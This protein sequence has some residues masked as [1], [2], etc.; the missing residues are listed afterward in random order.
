M[1]REQRGTEPRGDFLLTVLGSRGSIPVTRQEMREFGGDTSCYLLEARGERLV[2]DAGTGLANASFSQEGPVHILLS[3][4]H[5]DHLLGLPMFSGLLRKEGEVHL[6]GQSAGGL[7]LEKQLER[8][9]SPPLWP[10]RLQDYPA[11]VIC[12]PLCF[13]LRI[14]PF[15]VTGMEGCHPGGCAVLRVSACG[16]DLVYA[17]DFEHTPLKLRQLTEFAAGASLLLYDAQYTESMYEAK[18]GFGH[19]TAEMGLRVYSGSGARQLRF[20]HHDPQQT[21]A[22]LREREQRLGMPFARQGEVI[23]L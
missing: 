23:V 4:P 12:H 1:Q 21:D 8:L 14:G 18:K 9:I 11:R 22:M 13:P 6:Y 7:S 20:I 17:T 15:T 5:V 3:H 10:S 19:S 2:L 16:K